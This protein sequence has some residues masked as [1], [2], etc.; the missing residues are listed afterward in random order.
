MIKILWPLEKQV[1]LSNGG[2]KTKKARNKKKEE[3]T[4]KE[5]MRKQTKNDCNGKLQWILI[6][7]TLRNW[8]CTIILFVGQH[9]HI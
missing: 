9:C 1:S 2:T 4:M 7:V 8:L 6:K 5:N 3:K